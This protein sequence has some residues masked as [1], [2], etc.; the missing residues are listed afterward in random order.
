[1][2]KSSNAVFAT[3]GSDRSHA[4][5]EKL[6]SDVSRYKDRCRAL[7][8]Q[9]EALRNPE[10]AATA[11]AAAA[12][13]G[14]RRKSSDGGGSDTSARLHR[15]HRLAQTVKS[16]ADAAEKSSKV[17]LNGKKLII[18]QPQQLQSVSGSPLDL[19]KLKHRKK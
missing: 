16:S 10:L 12:A 7:Q 11:A 1:M 9:V 14:E 13:A 6:K 2:A 4:I 19:G 8:A 15:F 5:I 17:T 3:N 18:Q